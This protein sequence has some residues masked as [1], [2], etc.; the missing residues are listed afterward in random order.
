MKY[1]EC[2]IK[3]AL[4]LYPSGPAFGRSTRKDIQIGVQ[5]FDKM[6]LSIDEFLIHLLSGDYTIPAGVSIWI[7]VYFIH[8]NPKYYPN[9][10]EFNPDNFLPENVRNRH[11][12]AF[13]PFSAG[14]RSCLGMKYA[15]T[16]MKTLISYI[17]RNYSIKSLRKTKDLSEVHAMTLTALEGMYITLTSREKNINN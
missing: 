17:L 14:A 1:L 11:P 6:S 12:F 3:E 13:L 10:E 2:V 4:R 16:E 8:R 15:I 5:V 9:P 7:Q